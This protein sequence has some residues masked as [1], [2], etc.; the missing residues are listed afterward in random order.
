MFWC[1]ITFK[2]YN[3]SIF[4]LNYYSTKKICN[5]RTTYEP[6]H[7]RKFL[8]NVLALKSNKPTT[9]VEEDSSD[10]VLEY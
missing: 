8:E 3:Q 7:H 1:V 10:D 9:V 2:T 5:F 6:P 4:G